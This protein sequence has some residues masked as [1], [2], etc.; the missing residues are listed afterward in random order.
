MRRPAK[1]WRPKQ[2]DW[3]LL[4]TIWGDY[5][6][7]FGCLPSALP[8]R[9]LSIPIEHHPIDE[10][11]RERRLSEWR[12]TLRAQPRAGMEAISERSTSQRGSATR[13]ESRF[14]RFDEMMIALPLTEFSIFSISSDPSEH[15]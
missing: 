11:M 5:T 8:L 12:R 1:Q 4:G 2:I 6:P 3:T 15:R 10:Y 14:I 13:S 9:P 7:G